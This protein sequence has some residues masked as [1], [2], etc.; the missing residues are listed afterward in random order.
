[1]KPLVASGR[2]VVGGKLFQLSTKCAPIL[3][4]L[5]LGA[6]FDKHPAEGEPAQFRGSMIVYSAGSAEEV[7]EIIDQDIYATSGVWDLEKV[8]IIPVSFYP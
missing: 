2:L 7:R 6:M 1:M 3:I 8:Q 5:P 4:Y